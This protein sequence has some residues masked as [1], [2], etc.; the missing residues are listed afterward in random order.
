MSS[1]PSLEKRSPTANCPYPPTGGR[2]SPPQTTD[3]AIWKPLSGL[4]KGNKTNTHTNRDTS[5]G[6]DIF[7]KEHN[8]F[9]SNLSKDSKLKLNPFV[10]NPNWN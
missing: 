1:P 7:F 8:K 6:L 3:N 5:E 9:Q 10:K 4:D 2:F